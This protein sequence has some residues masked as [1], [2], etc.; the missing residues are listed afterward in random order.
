M[1]DFLEEAFPVENQVIP[2]QPVSAPEVQPEVVAEPAV[3]EPTAPEPVAPP[4]SEFIP[5]AALMDERDKR[6]AAEARVAE[7]ERSQQQR[8]PQ[9]VPDPFDDPNGYS[10]Y[11]Q[12]QM[13][14]AMA[15]QRMDT[16]YLIASKEYGKDA[17]E[18][19]REW[20]LER[21]KSNPGFAAELDQQPHPIDW[22][23][24]QHKRDGLIS[25]LPTD[26]SSLDELI[27]REIARRGLTATAAA[28]A[29]PVAATP[30]LKPAAP[31][32]SIASQVSQSAPITSDPLAEFNAIF[33]KR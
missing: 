26:V 7:I 11:F 2:D 3:V 18:S 24:Q 13:G 30:A 22:I 14:Q 21:G 15:Q 31:P 32:A 1:A 29:I 4:K 5:I 19:A 16:S 9:S 27:E 23:V 28:T 8:Q 33:S 17:V 25:Q 20:A 6:K 10:Q 12:S